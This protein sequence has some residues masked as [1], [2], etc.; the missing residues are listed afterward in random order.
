MGSSSTISTRPRG[1]TFAPIP[2]LPSML[3][4]IANPQTGNQTGGKAMLIGDCQVTG[5]EWPTTLL[6]GMKS[7]RV[8]VEDNDDAGAGR[9]KFQISYCMAT[10]SGS[11]SSRASAKS[12]WTAQRD[13][14]WVRMTTW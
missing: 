1:R 3:A 5:A 9:D 14:S 8:Y 2:T 4:E 11:S 10:A 13:F 7:V 12:Q 6:P